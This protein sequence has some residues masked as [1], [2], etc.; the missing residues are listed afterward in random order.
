MSGYNIR[1]TLYGLLNNI[2]PGLLIKSLDGQVTYPGIGT[3]TL[4]DFYDPTYRPVVVLP[5]S[6]ETIDIQF[7]LYSRNSPTNEEI[8]KNGDNDSIFVSRFDGRKPTK[9][10]ISAYFDNP[11][12]N[13]WTQKMRDQFLSLYDCNVIIVDWR[14]GNLNN[15]I[16]VFCHAKLFKCI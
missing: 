10:L 12:F 1:L 2:D 13:K 15:Y 6:P 14:G 4:N 7:L 5:Q 16:Q 3:F 9:I 8:L 11:D